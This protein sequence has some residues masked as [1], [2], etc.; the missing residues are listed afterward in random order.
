[1]GDASAGD[2]GIGLPE[3]RTPVPSVHYE[4]V[5]RAAKDVWEAPI[6][7]VGALLDT[8]ELPKDQVGLCSHLRMLAMMWGCANT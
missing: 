8:H 6:L 2:S 1:M 3:E 4:E 7:Y 5:D